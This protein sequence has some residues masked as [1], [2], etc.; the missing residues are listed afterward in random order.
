MTLTFAEKLK[1][2]R[3]A[4][5]LTQQ[6]MADQ[7]LIPRRTIQDWERGLF[8]PPEYVQRFVLNELWDMKGDAL[9]MVDVA[10][11]HEP[12]VG[13]DKPIFQFNFGDIVYDKT[14]KHSGE[15]IARTQTRYGL[16]TYELKAVPPAREIWVAVQ[17]M[18]EIDKNYK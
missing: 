10:K 1:A 9:V 5:G 8:D 2:L 12:S 6:G 7:M 16:I 18:L 14:H 11:D 17:E 4:A 13:A 15:V 3:K